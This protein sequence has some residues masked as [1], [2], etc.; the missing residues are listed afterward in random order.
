MT[1]SIDPG[2][3]EPKLKSALREI[4]TSTEFGFDN[5]EVDNYCSISVSGNE[6]EIRAEVD[7]DALMT[8]ANKLNPIIQKYN[9]EAY[10][11]AKEPGILVAML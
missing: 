4:M 1:E 3:L 5:S 6:V 7:Y 10:F 2:T 8:I 9:K 11:D